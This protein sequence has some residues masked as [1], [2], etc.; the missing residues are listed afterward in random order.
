MK[1]ILTG[2]VVMMTF[3][4]SVFAGIIPPDRSINWANCGI[5][6]KTTAQAKTVNVVKDF[7]AKADEKTDD[8]MAFVA[9]INSLTA[10]G[11]VLVPAGRYLIKNPI[12][13]GRDGIIIRGTGKTKPQLIFSFENDPAE[14]AL[15]MSGQEEG[16]W[17]KVKSG[18]EKGSTKL[19][20]EDPSV[21]NPGD[22]AEIQEENDPALHYTKL[23]WNQEWAQEIIGQVFR[24]SSVDNDSVTIDEPLHITFTAK[25]NPVIRPV[26]FIKNC[27]LEKIRL[28]RLDKGDGCMVAMKK[29]A[30]CWIRDVESEYAMRSHVSMEL[31]YRCEVKGSYFHHAHDYGGGG[32]GYGV[33]I[34]R[35]SSNNL[36]EK[37]EF[38]NLRHS[39][40][41]HLGAN[42]NVFG[43]NKSKQTVATADSDPDH[44]ICD[45]SVHGHYPFMNLFEGNIVQKIEVSD[46]WGPCGPGNTFLNNTVE[47][48]GIMVRDSSNYQNFIGNKVINK[49]YNIGN[50]STVDATTLILQ[51]NS[52]GGVIAWDDKISDRKVPETLYKNKP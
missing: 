2:L 36:V 40:M 47:G 13:I 19:F 9:A 14:D 30:Y 4:S 15:T 12:M 25:Q 45:I 29:A 34:K 32:H 31:S 27:G 22:F 46:Y 33:E 43:Y 26:K 28:K 50:D 7:G 39:M 20:V 37:N 1:K 21:F 35:H 41:V 48:E 17:T 16:G 23:E 44:L 18:L 6:G 3:S 42:G 38:F 8:S 49:A 51:G 10:G 11:I 24:V 5:P 52:C